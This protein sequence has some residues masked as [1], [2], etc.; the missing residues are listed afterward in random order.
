MNCALILEEYLRMCK[1]LNKTAYVAF[2]DAKC[3]FHVV[4]HD[5]LLHKL[6]NRG[7]EEKSWWVIHSLYHEAVSE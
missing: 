4:S 2:L 3:G 7:V 6:Y 1:D 5:S